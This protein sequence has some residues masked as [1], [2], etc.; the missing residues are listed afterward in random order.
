MYKRQ[1][2]LSLPVE[3]L[4]SPDAVRRLAWEPPPAS[5]ADVDAFLAE[6]LVRPWQREQVVPLLTALL[7]D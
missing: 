1:E 6:R 4:I 5:E 3:N 2:E 7:S